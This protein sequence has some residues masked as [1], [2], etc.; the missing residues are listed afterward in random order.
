MKFCLFDPGTGLYSET[1]HGLFLI[2]VRSV[3]D[4]PLTPLMQARETRSRYSHNPETLN[5]PSLLLLFLHNKTAQPPKF[6]LPFT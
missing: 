4:V 5:R 3:E 6:S 2:L 1:G